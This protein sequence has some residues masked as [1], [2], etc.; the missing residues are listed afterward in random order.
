M[1]QRCR[2]WM[3]WSVLVLACTTIG[4]AQDENPRVIS[5]T[6][7]GKASVSPDMATINTGVISEA[8]TAGEA[9]ILNSATMKKIM[10]VLTEMKIEARDVQTSNF[11]VNP[12][13]SRDPQRRSAPQVTG[14]QVSNTVRVHVRRLDQLGSILDALVTSGSNRING[15]SFGVEDQEGALKDARTRAI[16]NAMDRANQYAAAAGVKVVAV[17]SISEQPAQIPRPPMMGRMAMAEAGSAVPIAT[18]ELDFNVSVNVVF[19][20]GN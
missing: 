8:K 17:R 19:D 1:S 16:S 12:V 15:V 7:Q 10:A 11:S 5:V 18:G 6:G 3:V 14:Y 13:Y 4:K 2:G 20:L 9:L